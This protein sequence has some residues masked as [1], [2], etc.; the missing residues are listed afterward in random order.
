MATDNYRIQESREVKMEPLLF[1]PV[2][3]EKIWGGRNLERVLGKRLPEGKIGESFE[4]ACRRDGDTV[5]CRGG[6]EGR[7]LSEL[8]EEDP[9]GL[10]GS[11]VNEKYGGRFPMLLKILD[12]NDVLSVQVHPTDEYAAL[13]E[14][15][16]DTGKEETWYVI[17]A[18]GNA[19]LIKGLKK[20]TTRE[21]FA[22]LLSEGHLEEC[23][24][25]F[26]VS[27]G[28][29]VHVP[30][31]TVHAIGAG[32]MLAEI[33]RNSNVTYRVYDWGRVGADGSSRS[34][35]I[36]QAMEVIDWDQDLPDKVAVEVIADDGR[37]VHERLFCCDFY[38][39]ESYRGAGAF[40]VESGGRA[41]RM[42]IV[43]SGA[44]RMCC[45]GRCVN[46]AKGESYLIPAA[47]DRLNCDVEDAATVLVV[48]P[49]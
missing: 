29:V 43:L 12:A 14:G 15:G 39:I 2:F 33:Q 35:H 48:T 21:D 47:M 40:A 13:Y 10:M 45:G 16:G 1:A 11:A 8:V 19:K 5:V 17:E 28:D 25:T 20:G 44:G 41:F 49:R 26:A 32:L 42:V 4:I 37:L 30:T 46:V 3:V 6:N 23:L 18:R 36:E 22:R 7:R 31:G 38:E 34:L 24:N 9:A 27:P